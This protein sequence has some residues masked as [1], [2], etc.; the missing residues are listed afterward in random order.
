MSAT[1]RYQLVD[2]IDEIFNAFSKAP[3]D[4]DRIADTLSYERIAIRRADPRNV[5]LLVTKRLLRLIQILFLVPRVPRGATILFQ[6]PREDVSGRLGFLLLSLLRNFRRIK[7][8]TLVHDLKDGMRE[9][10][11]GQNSIWIARERKIKKWSDAFIVHNARMAEWAAAHGVAPEKTICLEIFDYLAS[12]PMNH[13]AF[14]R[15]VTIAGNLDIG[16]RKSVYLTELRKITDVTWELYGPNFDPARIGGDNIAYKGCVQPDELPQRLDHGFGLVWDG[17]SVDTC[18]GPYG[19]YLKLNNPH[20]LSLYLASGLPV[21]I[22][23][24]AAEAA[25]VEK[26]KV[27]LTVASLRELPTVLASITEEQYATLA[28]NARDIGNRLRAGSFTKAA[29]EAA[30]RLIRSGD[31]RHPCAD[32]SAAGC[33]CATR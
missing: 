18:S 10:E 32:A 12:T 30:E 4:I 27:G 7:L 2:K 19:V 6:Y 23:N 5:F 16:S 14:S 15:A 33:G 8:I 29:V 17:E 24:E 31:P 13:P 25:F 22:W 11:E 3:S 21:I 9:T 28:A 1:K 20:K 26:H